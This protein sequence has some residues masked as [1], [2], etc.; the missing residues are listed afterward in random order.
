MEEGQRV[1]VVRRGGYQPVGENLDTLNPPQGGTGVPQTVPQ[2]NDGR[3]M[4]IVEAIDKMF[5]V[6][7]RRLKAYSQEDFEE[8]LEAKENAQIQLSKM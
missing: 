8:F 4:E 2:T 7:T 6:F 3:K 1:R 5:N